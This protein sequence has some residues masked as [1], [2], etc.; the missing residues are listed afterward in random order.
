MSLPENPLVVRAA[1]LFLV[2][3][4]DFMLFRRTIVLPKRQFEAARTVGEST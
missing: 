1:F 2:L 4:M 3:A